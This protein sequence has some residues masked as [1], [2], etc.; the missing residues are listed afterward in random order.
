M[1]IPI[2]YKTNTML[3]AIKQMPINH[4]FLRDRYFP[5]TES[6]MFPGSTV[7]VEYKNGSRKLAP[8]V[9]PKKKGITVER[10]GYY[11]SLYEPPYIAPQRPLG[12]DD[13]EKKQFGEILFGDMSQ[14]EREQKIL[15]SDL[16]EFDEMITR[17]EEYLAA[18]IMQYN[19]V[20]VK[21][22]ADKYGSDEFE[23]YEVRFYEDNN[24]AIYTPSVDWNDPNAPILGDLDAMTQMLTG[25]GNP[26][27]DVVMSPIMAQNILRNLQIKELLDNSNIL[28]GEINPVEMYG[29]QA[30]FL[31]QLKATGH[32]LNLI[33]YNGQYADES[34][35]LKPYLDPYSVIVTAPEAGRGMYGA[36]TQLEDDSDNFLIYKEKR[37]PKFTKDVNTDVRTLK[38]T[39]RPFFAPKTLNPFICAK[40]SEEE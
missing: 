5:T 25:N 34:G 17:N 40:V 37:V 4:S 2:L 28:I 19:Q 20:T 36:V 6:D 11:S 30:G 15:A 8:F 18:Q 14:N 10:T 9:I 21:H 24:E 1:A 26:A 3:L 38:M 12:I 16:E 39:S 7:I 31:G 35:E 33:T 27:V 29:G 23:E 13:L 22:Y 32:P